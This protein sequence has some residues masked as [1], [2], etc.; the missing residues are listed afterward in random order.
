MRNNNL[1]RTIGVWKNSEARRPE[2]LRWTLGK[3]RA[4]IQEDHAR[5]KTIPE[6]LRNWVQEDAVDFR[7]KQPEIRRKFKEIMQGNPE[8]IQP[9]AERMFF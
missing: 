5:T 7:D 3:I 2:N 1:K 4:S 9:T 8:A 6:R